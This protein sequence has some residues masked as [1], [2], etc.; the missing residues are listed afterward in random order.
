MVFRRFLPHIREELAWKD[1]EA[2]DAHEVASR[3]L[4]FAVAQL[5]VFKR[6]VSRVPFAAV[7]IRGEVLGDV[8]V[9]EH[10]E[11]ILLEIPA[12]DGPSEVVR[13]R[14]YRAMKLFALLRFHNIFHA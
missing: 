14:P 2:L 9:K 7:H 5:R 12:V 1:E 13:D 11:D 3:R 8:A 10:A 4:G 6:F